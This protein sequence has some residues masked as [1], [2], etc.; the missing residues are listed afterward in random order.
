MFSN[1]TGLSG[2]EQRIPRFYFFQPDYGTNITSANLADR[3]ILVRH[4]AHQPA[5]PQLFAGPAV[6]YQR[7]SLQYA[8]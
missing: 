4:D 3:F 1:T 6:P 8:E 5:Y 7:T 2:S